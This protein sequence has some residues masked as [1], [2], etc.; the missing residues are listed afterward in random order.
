MAS[1]PTTSP[2]HYLTGTSAMTIPS[3]DTSFVD[4]HF[5]D[6]FIN[7]KARFR[8]A[9]KDMPDT[10]ALLGNFGVRECSDTLR[11]GGVKLSERQS[12]W[13][14]NRDRALL[15]MIISNVMKNRRPDHI[16]L[17]QYFEDE[18]DR[19]TFEQQLAKVRTKTEA[20]LHPDLLDQWIAQQ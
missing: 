9:G 8:V 12:V 16:R 13:A 5:V 3:S 2:E 1:L 11:R 17:E 18:A 4:W 6:T 10:S 14:A 19:K 20:L 15:D 7:E